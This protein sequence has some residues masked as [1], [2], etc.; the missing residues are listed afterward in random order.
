MRNKFA[1]PCYQCGENVP[2]G[3]GFFERLNGRWRVQHRLCCEI[4]RSKK[5]EERKSRE[6]SHG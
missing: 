4:A 6:A 3:A 5:A 1:G 2:T